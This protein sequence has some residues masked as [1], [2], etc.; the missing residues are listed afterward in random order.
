MGTRV[1]TL[2][3]PFWKDSKGPEDPPVGGC[4]QWQERRRRKT[5][6][7][8]RNCCLGQETGSALGLGPPLASVSP[9][10]KPTSHLTLEASASQGAVLTPPPLLPPAHQLLTNGIFPLP[11]PQGAHTQPAEGDLLGQGQVQRR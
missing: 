1:Y 5:Q 6:A 7:G 4:L 3:G 11:L 9:A 2:D 8:G 10:H